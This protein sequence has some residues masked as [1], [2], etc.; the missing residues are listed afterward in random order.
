MI[1]ESPATTKQ[2]PQ[3]PT[4]RLFDVPI[5]ALTMDEVLAV[6][7]ETIA[8]DARLLIGAVNA[9]KVVNMRRHGELRR[10][11]LRADMILADGMAVVWASRL[12]KRA[13]PERVPGIDL[14]LGMLRQGDRR[15]YRVYCLGA[16]AESLDA[17]VAR[18]RREY[19][20]VVIAGQRCGY[21]QPEEEAGIVSAIKA[22]RADILFVGMSPPK[23]E[24]FLARWASELDVPV[25]H[26]VGGAFDVLSG[27]VRRA[28]AYLQR[29]GLE[30]F[31]RVVQEPRRMWRRYLVT[32]IAFGGL[33][34]RELLVGDRR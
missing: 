10:A 23:K 13:L 28:P 7:D 24:I 4:R 8:S 14:M 34:L 18:I 22:S 30:W 19:P 26:G 33:V 11:V 1:V 2:R 20:G 21:Y 3:W 15:R 6:V 12:L 27:K 31:H 25:C 9:A 32:N 5:H 17:A 29:M 16:T